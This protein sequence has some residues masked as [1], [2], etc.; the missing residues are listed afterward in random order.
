MAWSASLWL[1]TVP[2]IQTTPLLSVSTLMSFRLAICSAASFVLI[3][4]VMAESLTKVAGFA[5]SASVSSANATGANVAPITKQAVA[6][7]YFMPDLLRWLIVSGNLKHASSA[8]TSDTT[9]LSCRTDEAPLL[10]RTN[11]RVY[12][13]NSAG[14]AYRM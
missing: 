6:S 13:Q 11:T 8:C 5:R 4:V 12:R 9:A 3:F 7:L 14:Y 1:L 10:H 2:D